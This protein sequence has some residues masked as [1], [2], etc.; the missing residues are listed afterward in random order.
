MTGDHSSQFILSC[1]FLMCLYI[2]TSPSIPRAV[3]PEVS[4]ESSTT[5]L[6]QRS[7]D[8]SESPASSSSISVV[9]D[10]SSN[11]VYLPCFMI[12]STVE[13]SASLLRDIT[14]KLIPSSSQPAP[15]VS[16]S[17]TL[18]SWTSAVTVCLPTHLFCCH[19][20]EHLSMVIHPLHLAF[21]TRLKYTFISTCIV[22]WAEVSGTTNVRL[23]SKRRGGKLSQAA[24]RAKKS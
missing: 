6:I 22:E 14:S 13:N 12:T 5:R 17:N 3:Q 23:P 15:D 24:F 19:L 8:V 2:A 18:S 20:L 7:R 11:C 4:T 10:S 16:A 1:L 21:N 9:T